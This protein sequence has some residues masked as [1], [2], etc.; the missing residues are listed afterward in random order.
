MEEVTEGERR[1][2]GEE[3]AVVQCVPFFY[4]LVK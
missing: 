2:V 4:L 1:I 3:R